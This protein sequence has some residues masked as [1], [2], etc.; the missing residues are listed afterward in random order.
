MIFM[1][2]NLNPFI[3]QGKEEI[4]MKDLKYKS[5]M[6]SLF[7]CLF[8]VCTTAVATAGPIILKFGWTT[9]AGETDPYAISARQF[10]KALDE[11]AG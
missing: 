1:P 11:F 2:Q 7:I 5:L 3:K 4:E 8:I 9:A 6:A 10:K